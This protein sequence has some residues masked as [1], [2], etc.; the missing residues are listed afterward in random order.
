[1]PLSVCLLSD[2]LLAGSSLAQKLPLV[3]ARNL[4][5]S[6]GCSCS[7]LPAECPKP[8]EKELL[9]N[10]QREMLVLLVVKYPEIHCMQ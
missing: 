9:L 2:L 1:M 6:S 3:W 5:C 8:S 10:V 4:G 7:D